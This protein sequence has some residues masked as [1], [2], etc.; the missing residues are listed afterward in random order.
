ME[1]PEYAKLSS[2]RVFSFEV[3]RA[4]GRGR[5]PGRVGE[6]CDVGMRERVRGKRRS[7]VGREVA[8]PIV[9]PAAGAQRTDA[10]ILP[11]AVEYQRLADRGALHTARE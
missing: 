6:K 2:T 9:S 11:Q 3:Q 5:G 7:L 4:R 10:F 1:V 8:Q